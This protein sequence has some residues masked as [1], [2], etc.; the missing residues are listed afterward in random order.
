[1]E[2]WNCYVA[3]HIADVR[4]KKMPSAPRQLCDIMQSHEDETADILHW[5]KV[6]LSSMEGE[7]KPVFWIRDIL[8]RIRI[9]GPYTQ[10]RIWI[11][12]RIL[13]FSSVAYLLFLGTFTSAFKDRK[14]QNSWNQGFSLFFKLIDGG[15]RI[16]KN[17]NG[18]WRPKNLSVSA[19]CQ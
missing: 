16:R 17:N 11:R 13:L 3:R 5:Q 2:Q 12:I 10:L 14:S 7:G 1:M 6:S 8:R 4:K 15:I 19:M 9:L 18:S